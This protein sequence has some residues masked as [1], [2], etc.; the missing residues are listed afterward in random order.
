MWSVKHFRQ[1][2]MMRCVQRTRDIGVLEFVVDGEK[3]VMMQ[4]MELN[5]E[6]G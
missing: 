1:R 6:D 4:D 5:K 3:C 2:E